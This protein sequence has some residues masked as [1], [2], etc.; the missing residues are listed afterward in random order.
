MSAARWF[1]FGVV[2]ALSLHAVG[3]QNATELCSNAC[4]FTSDDHSTCDVIG[5]FQGELVAWSKCSQ[6]C[7]DAFSIRIEGVNRFQVE[8]MFPNPNGA[9]GNVNSFASFLRFDS[10][11][12]ANGA[13]AAFGDYF[14]DDNFNGIL[15]LISSGSTPTGFCNSQSACY[16]N[17]KSYLNTP[18]GQA[19]MEDIGQTL[20]LQLQLENELEQ[21]VCRI[22]MCNVH[23]GVD[24]G[25]STA[26]SHCYSVY[27]EVA[28]RESQVFGCS[29]FGFGP[30]FDVTDPNPDPNSQAYACGVSAAHNPTS[31]ALALPLLVAALTALQALLL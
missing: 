19:I 24:S 30:G 15:T 7:L 17:L 20:W 4:S 28:S 2:V 29:A 21:S 25:R 27:E 18:A 8:N 11:S 1:C 5:K 14:K 16:D 13:R 9:N 26:L 31:A 22:R 3:A 23:R 10:S 6:V 12:T